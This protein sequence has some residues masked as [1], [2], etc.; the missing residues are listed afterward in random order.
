M[1]QK[2]NEITVAQAKE[3]FRQAVANLKPK[4]SVADNLLVF[5]IISF[6]AGMIIGES[7]QTRESLAEL[8]V[9]VLK[10]AL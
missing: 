2:N 5:A 7:K 8:L 1:R 6:I 9:T 4:K 3:E 10:K